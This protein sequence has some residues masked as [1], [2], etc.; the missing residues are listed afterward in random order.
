MKTLRQQTLRWTPRI[1]GP[2]FAA[3][4]SVF[5]LDV[6]D[7]HHGFW[8]TA[9]ALAM[10]LIPTALLLVV[11]GLSWRWE[12]IGGIVFPML[13]VLYLVMFWGRFPWSV[14]ALIAGPLFLLGALFLLSWSR[15][16]AQSVVA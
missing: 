10:H 12:W 4:L 3:F 1:L 5:A 13:G 7:R 6:F 2:L 11:V 16:R 9:L 14:Y 15:R 8:Q